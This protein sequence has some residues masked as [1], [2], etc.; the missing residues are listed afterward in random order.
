MYHAQSGMALACAREF[1]K[2]SSFQAL[3]C[4]LWWGPSN[5]R[6]DEL[7]ISLERNLLLSQQMENF[8]VTVNV[9]GLGR[10]DLT[11]DLLDLVC[12]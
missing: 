5:L 12:D 8:L 6:S 9:V 3:W 10:W 11:L 4:L 2:K 1:G 7:Y